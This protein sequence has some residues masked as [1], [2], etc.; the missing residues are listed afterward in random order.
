MVLEV[1]GTKKKLRQE[2][3]SIKN[4]AKKDY[5]EN[6]EVLIMQVSTSIMQYKNQKVLE[7]KMLIRSLFS[8]FPLVVVSSNHFF[9]VSNVLAA[10]LLGFELIEF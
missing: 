5:R 1:E 8:K 3:S 9:L 2:I 10:M 7:A 4:E 6:K